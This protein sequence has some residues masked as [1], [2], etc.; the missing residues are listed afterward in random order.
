MS[1]FNY[2]KIMGMNLQNTWQTK[3]ITIYGLQKI[4]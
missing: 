2:I 4:Q 3:F 1:K